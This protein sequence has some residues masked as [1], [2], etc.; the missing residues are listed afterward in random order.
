MRWTHFTLPVGDLDATVGFFTGVCGLSV[1]RD[2]RL[3][4]GTT[5]WL[6]P[7][8]GLDPEFV[9]VLVRGEVH[10]PLDHFGF[11]CDRRDQVTAIAERAKAD[12]TLVEGPTDYGGSVGYFAVVREPSGHL[13]EFTHGQPLRGLGP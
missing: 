6:G 7:A 11:Q 5:V 1:V 12:G 13:V 9:V 3:E 10:A 8:P 2:R 4:G